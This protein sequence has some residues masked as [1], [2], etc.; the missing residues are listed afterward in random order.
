MVLKRGGGSQP[1]QINFVQDNTVGVG[2]RPPTFQPER[3]GNVT[4]NCVD[5]LIGASHQAHN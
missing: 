1:P 5:I 4:L 2:T 3:T